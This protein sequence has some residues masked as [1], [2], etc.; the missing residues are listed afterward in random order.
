MPQLLK[1][2]AAL[3]TAASSERG[4]GIARV[5]AQN[6]CAVALHFHKN[7]DHAEK[8]QE[9]IEGKKG[10]AVICQADL[11]SEE[12]IDNLFEKL[13]NSMGNIDILVNNAH[14]KITRRSFPEATWQ[15]CQD[16]MNVILKGSWHT[17]RCFLRQVNQNNGG[18]IIQILSGQIN[19]PIAGYS[20]FSSALS[21]LAGFS[22]SLALEAAPLGVR[23]NAIAP[24]FIKTEKTPNAPPWVQEKILAETPLGRLANPEDL[25]KGVLFF[26][27]HLSEFITGTC[28]T[29][30]GG[31]ELVGFS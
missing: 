21:A 24:G 31:R 8:L 29:L 2:K 25:G 26:A 7:Q 5:L 22:K 15:E 10:K 9:E 23:V 27:S 16:Q 28:M 12:E 18:S 20:A 19:Q 11:S 4:V 6:G 1:G 17:C 3:I 13:A 14:A 30:D